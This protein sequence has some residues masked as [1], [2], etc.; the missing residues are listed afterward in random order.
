M[1]YGR[2]VKS[3]VSGSAPWLEAASRADKKVTVAIEIGNQGPVRLKTRRQVSSA[4][5]AIARGLKRQP[6][7]SACQGIAVHHLDLVSSPLVS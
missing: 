7:Y 4:I 3:V 5:A 1:A 6:G 2:S